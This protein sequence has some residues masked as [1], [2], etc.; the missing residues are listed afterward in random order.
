MTC[1]KGYENYTISEDGIIMNQF[2]KEIKPHINKIRYC[3]LG[4]YK[5]GKCK[6]FLLHRLLALTFISNPDNLPE[7]DHIDR[8][9]SNNNLEN[10][11]WVTHLQNLQNIGEYK[12]NT[13]GI[14]NIRWCK[15]GK[16][17]KF[18]KQINGKRHTNRSKD[19]QVVIDF[20]AKFYLE[21]NLK[22]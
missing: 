1:I 16:C 9:R 8:N 15:K 5:N 19:K 12:N 11:H 21:H 14:K 2:G 22:D 6:K 13:S 3:R 18:Q 4:L 20:K 7:V 17:W 10:L